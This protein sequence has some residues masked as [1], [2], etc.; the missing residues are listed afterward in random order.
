[1]NK[2]IKWAIPFAV[3]ALTCG[4]TAAG[5]NGCNKHEHSYTEWGYNE[6]QHWKQCPEDDE[7][8]QSTKEDHEFVDGSCEC[9]ATQ[10][11]PPVT[12]VTITNETTDTNGTVTLSKTTVKAGESVT[13]TVAPN[14]GYQLKSL[15]VNGANVFGAM[16]DNTYTFTAQENTTV[17]A[18]FEK[19]ASSSVNSVITGKKYGVTGNSLT[20][21]TT[22]TL[23]AEGRDDIATEIKAD[24]DNLVIKV[25]EIAGDNWSVKV[26]GYVAATIIVPRDAEYTSAI[27]LEYD[28]MENLSTSWG[29]YDGVDLSKQN[30]GKIT[31]AGGYYQWV[32]SKDSYE[33]VA[34][35]ANVVKGGFRQ[36]V[37]IRFKG[38][39]YADDGFVMLAKENQ[40][41]ISVCGAGDGYTGKNLWKDNWDEYLNP[42]AKDEYELTLV[43]D[44]ANI[45]IFIDG[46]YKATKALPEGY[47]DKE[48]YVGLFCTDATKME[49]SER[50]FSIGTYDDFFKTVTITDTTETGAKGSVT[51]PAGEH[52]VG[53]QVEIIVTPDSGYVVGSFTVNGKEYADRIANGKVT[54]TLTK[55]TVEVKATFVE[56]AFTASNEVCPQGTYDFDSYIV[57]DKLVLGYK[58]YNA[59]GDT[60]SYGGLIGNGLDGITR[61]G[62]DFNGNVGNINFKANGTTNSNC[63][64]L[65]NGQYIDVTV[66][67]PKNAKQILVFTGTYDGGDK[68]ITCNLYNA[69]G[70]CVGNGTF[71]HTRGDNPR[72]DLVTFNVDTSEFGADGETFT[73]RIGGNCST[74]VAAIAVLGEKYDVTITNGT[75]DENG[76]VT[77]EGTT[78]NKITTG[79]KV[80]VALE[81]KFGY[82][83]KDI[84]V[85][86]QS[87]L[88]SVVNNVYTFVAIQDTTVVAEFEQLQLV[89]V[90]LT[91]NAEDFAGNS[92]ALAVGKTVTF[93]DVNGYVTY[94]YTVGG[95]DNFTQMY[96]GTYIVTCDGY[97]EK[98]ITVEADNGEITVNFS[99][100]IAT[101]SENDTKNEIAVNED[102]T[103]TIHGNG[104]ADRTSD[105]AIS[106]DLKLT[107]EQKRATG[108]TLTFTVKGTKKDNRGGDDWAAS[109][110]G[111]QLGE[112]ALGFFVFARNN[113][114]PTAADIVKLP[115]NSLG[116][117]GVEHKWHGDDPALAWLT[118]A[119]FSENGLQMKVERK[120]GVISVYAKNGENWVLLSKD[121]QNKDNGGTAN[122]A[123]SSGGDLTIANN[124]LN[125][126]KFL[127]CGDHWTFSDISVTLPAESEKA[128]L[129]TSVNDKTLGNIETDVANY[130]KGDKAIITVT[131]NQGYVLEKL[132]I[133][134]TEV[135]ASE[136][137]KNGLE[138]IYEYTLTGDTTVVAYIIETPTP[139]VTPNVTVSGG[140]YGSTE[141]PTVAEGTTVTL[142]NAEMET[143]YVGT[144]GADGKLTFDKELYVATYKVSAEGYFDGEITIT[145]NVTEPIELKLYVET[146]DC[147]IT[148]GETGDTAKFVAEGATITFSLN[149]ETKE[150]TVTDGKVKLEN[151]LT[152]AWETTANFGGYDL[153]LGWTTV[154]K[155]GTAS[156]TV[157]AAG[158][159]WS[160][161]NPY[162]HDFAGVDINGATIEV[163]TD[164]AYHNRLKL[165]TAKEG[166]VMA[167][168]FSLP[169]DIK[170]KLE[171]GDGKAAV[172]MPIGNGSASLWVVFAIEKSGA[173]KTI[174]FAY[175]DK[176]SYGGWFADGGAQRLDLSSYWDTLVS[177][178]LWVVVDVNAKSAAIS[179]YVG[180]T[181]ETAVNAKYDRTCTLAPLSFNQIEI[182]N[183]LGDWTGENVCVTF[184]YGETLTAL[185]VGKNVTLAEV[186][187]EVTVGGTDNKYTA[188]GATLV[189]NHINGLYS[190]EGEVTNSK[191]SLNNIPVGEYKV[192]AKVNGLIVDLGSITVADGD[193]NKTIALEAKPVFDPK[194]EQ[195]YAG[196]DLAEGSFEII[197]NATYH[198]KIQFAQAGNG[199]AL[200]LKF[201]L[202]AGT[203]ASSDF[204]AVTSMPLNFADGSMWI[205][206]RLEKNGD[207]KIAKFGFTSVD[208]GEYWGKDGDGYLDLSEQWD[209]I[210]NGGLWVVV[211][212]DAA[213]GA[214]KTYTGASL[215]TVQDANFNRTCRSGNRI[216][217]ALEIG[218]AIES[219]D[220]NFCITLAY[221][222]TLDEVKALG[223]KWHN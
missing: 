31:H 133:G 72:A 67:I 57:N 93:E 144:V 51:L 120:N 64:F 88:A 17:V 114:A 188:E 204:K 30:D 189:F 15:T 105:R 97:F 34:I 185:N 22:V 187:A 163:K 113:S 141:I 26:D 195:N 49:N 154:G 118:A 70:N 139:Q 46:E 81:P 98:T 183:A 76:T 168:R 179:T 184:K 127:G 52:K 109:R 38:D 129:T 201:A 206:F 131:V 196:Y 92:A 143:E 87:V 223:G 32:S 126:I 117:N 136:C 39:T 190:V 222:E 202:P 167:F 63:L 119:A 220:T 121:E 14:E 8:D 95:T 96:A 103:I 4:I 27:A 199:G 203:D 106:A 209:T 75:T 149:G 197:T 56:S 214:V 176:V 146:V 205:V 11:T 208:G 148:V 21:G 166:G 36:G 164:K 10:Q 13:V 132:V 165:A 194:Q 124:V 53:E 123:P 217:T 3:L 128:T 152:G 216:I 83:I 135:L 158:I 191:V 215:D 145:E 41:K 173:N 162:Q 90:T 19:I 84:K 161:S 218:N 43:R 137:T 107:D 198:N 175:H 44:G 40:Q 47:A 99:E 89:D 169:A 213:N 102:K 45:Y 180:A 59:A 61:Y 151:V 177:D 104:I 7:I 110:F 100:P 134:E 28:L 193:A 147:E 101:P 82:R 174:K 178:G 24:G 142:T 18:V 74:T 85:N 78:G 33:S 130:Y 200:A 1:M 186:N 35:T 23:S 86:G 48:C 25:D 125:E 50:T 156:V 155:S 73:L 210:V 29:N 116:M 66:K 170:T 211:D 68:T 16:T 182:G 5:C 69:D 192:G 6:T 37:F 172:T 2:K 138:Y 122:E 65:D 80:T 115:E 207:N 111:V 77:I 112:G 153:H 219:T 20:A 160:G 140:K 212:I 60:P 58:R 42:L 221:G 94:D 91:L 171:S 71:L 157:D 159:C 9:G 108:L 62:D 54:V 79:E 150:V 12:D 55:A 181:L